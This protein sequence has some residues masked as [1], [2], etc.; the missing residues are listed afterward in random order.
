M[1]VFAL[2][3]RRPF[4]DKELV[5]IVVGRE[6]ASGEVLH[7]V[8]VS[9]PQPSSIL[10][11]PLGDSVV[12]RGDMMAVVYEI[13]LGRNFFLRSAYLNQYLQDHRH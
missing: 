8:A 9:Y 7:S 13:G 3:F 6:I 10:K 11:T 2:E 1:H 4:Q 12:V 5:V